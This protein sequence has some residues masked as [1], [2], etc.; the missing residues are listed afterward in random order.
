VVARKCPRCDKNVA[1]NARF[2][3]ACGVDLASELHCR[4]CQAKLPPGTKFCFSCGEAI[5]AG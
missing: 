3:S 5:A 2:C 4:H 1:A